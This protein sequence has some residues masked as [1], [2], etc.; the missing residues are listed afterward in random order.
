[1]AREQARMRSA[2]EMPLEALPIERQHPLHPPFDLGQLR[3]K[4]PLCRLAYP[5]GHVG[6]VVTS[7]SLARSVLGDGRFSTRWDLMR[8]PVRRP[9]TEG[10]FHGPTVSGWF[11]GMDPP[12]HTRFR[13][14]LTGRFTMRR[15]SD[16]QPRIQRIVDDHLDAMEDTGPPVDLVESFAVPIPGMAICELLGVPEGDREEFQQL[17]EALDSLEG[18]LAEGTAAWEQLTKRL[19]KLIEE[20]AARP[21]DDLLS[22]LVG[23]SELSLDELT[24]VAALLVDGGL[25]T[26]ANMLALGVFALLSHPEKL[27]GL[28][29]N[30]A[31]MNNAVEELLRYLTIFQFGTTRTALEDV[32]LEGQLIKADETITVSLPAANRDPEKYSCPDELELTRVTSGHLAFGHGVHMCLG[33]HLAR[34]ELRVGYSS[35]F[36]RFPKLRLAAAADS[37]PTRDDMF[38]YGVHELPVRW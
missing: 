1:M 6:W 37:I 9:A 28:R 15:M 36:R 29:A 30:P 12:E 10:L 27:E 7:H 32:Y 22:D 20:K 14:L 25:S 34:I 19:R 38:I 21:G 26:T 35:L 33:Q 13:R 16:L 11:L 5:D 17:T 23:T 4:R 8:Q 2:A 24:G 31:S 3:E 18:T